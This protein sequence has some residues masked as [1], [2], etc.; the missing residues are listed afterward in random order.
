MNYDL[1]EVVSKYLKVSEVFELIEPDVMNAEEL[2]L[3]SCTTN[4]PWFGSGNELEVVRWF[5]SEE[6]ALIIIPTRLPAL[7]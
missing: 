2:R 3:E 6:R 4:L 7:V 1:E 5:E